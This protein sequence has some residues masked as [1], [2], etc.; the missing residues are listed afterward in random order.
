MSTFSNNGLKE[1]W[2]KGGKGN[3]TRYIP[4]HT[5][6]QRLGRDLCSVLP[7]LHR[8]K[9]CDVTSKIGTKKAALNANPCIH[10]TSFGSLPFTSKDIIAAERFLVNVLNRNRAQI[11]YDELK[12]LFIQHLC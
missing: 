8:L 2:V 10:L 5:L 6:F 9:S 12:R 3:T 11:N 4:I 7:A 1:L